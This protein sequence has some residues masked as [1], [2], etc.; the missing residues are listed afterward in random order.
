MGRAISNYLLKHHYLQEFTASESEH[1]NRRSILDEGDQHIKISGDLANLSKGN[2]TVEGSAST[3]EFNKAISSYYNREMG[4]G[5]IQK[6]ALDKSINPLVGAQLAIQTLGAR[7]D[8]ANIYT[9]ISKNLVARYPDMQFTKDYVQLA[10]GLAKQQAMRMAGEK[11]KVGQPAP[12]IKLPSPDGKE[13]ALSDLKGQVVLLD[14]WASWCGPCRKAN[15]HVVETYKKYKDKGFTVFSV[16]LDGLDSRT[17][18]R[19]QSEDM[20]QTANEQIQGSLGWCH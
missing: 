18:K 1:K 20:I 13:Y 2:Y 6:F 3:A 17:K 15:P 5:D 19:F 16:S 4:I 12:D 14:F 7:P 11:I 10:D 8:F 9:D